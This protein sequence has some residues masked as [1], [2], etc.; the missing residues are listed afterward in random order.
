MLPYI[1][2]IGIVEFPARAG[3]NPLI[4]LFVIPVGV[5][6]ASGVE[7]P[8]IVGFGKY[9]ARVPRASGVEPTVIIEK[10]LS[11]KSSPRE[12]G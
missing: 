8:V 10:I 3:L 6:R 9:R 5:P 11:L 1:V 12:R 7:P 2:V 4:R